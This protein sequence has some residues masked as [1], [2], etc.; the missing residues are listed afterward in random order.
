MFVQ[1]TTVVT[2]TLAASHAI[3]A[4]AAVLSDADTIALRS[5][6]VVPALF[7][8]ADELFDCKG[9]AKYAERYFQVA[10]MN[11]PV[12]VEGSTLLEVSTRTESDEQIKQLAEALLSNIQKISSPSHEKQAVA[13]GRPAGQAGNAWEKIGLLLQCFLISVAFLIRMFTLDRHQKP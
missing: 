7:K 13:T 3:A 11:A 6:N 12:A 10:D 2:V 1:V 4:F 9:A 8:G 5:R